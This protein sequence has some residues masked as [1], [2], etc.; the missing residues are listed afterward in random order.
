MVLIA[1]RDL[2]FRL[3]RFLI[4]VVAV[5][6]VLALTMLLAGVAASFDI[7]VDTMIDRLDV[8][9]WLV[10]SE[11]NGPFLSAV[12]VP[13]STVDVV[14]ATDGVEQAAPMGFFS[15]TIGGHDAPRPVVLFGVEP[16]AVGSPEP[17][18]GVA[19]AGP[20]QA[21]V[22]R[23]LGLDQGETLDI[24]GRSL[25]V[26]GRFD[27]A[28]LFGGQPTAFITMDDLQQIAY[29]GAP[30]VSPIAIR[31][32]PTQV[33]PGLKIQTQADARADLIRPIA[34]AKDTITSAHRLA[35][36][37]GRLHHRLGHL[38]LGPR[39]GSRLRGVQGDRRAHQLGSRRTDHAS[40][41]A[42]ARGVD[43]C[44]RCGAVD[45]ARGLDPGEV[46]DQHHL[47]RA[48]HRRGRGRRRQ[49]GGRSS[50]GEG[51]PCIGVRMRTYAEPGGPDA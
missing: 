13:E 50:C 17:D 41:R 24:G 47:V 6:L 2:Q 43:R 12:P 4:S 49:P 7:E 44:D 1:F 16:G 36:A 15:T 18:E 29:T 11:A 14:A 39:A 3:R 19:L 38:P 31:G 45:R 25:E 8:D 30:V 46:A 42:H 40:G 33:P 22:D 9:N 21:V 20:G 34:P 48:R 51:R 28:T 23:T 10:S 32:E 27:S 37:R 5:A 26:V 35:V